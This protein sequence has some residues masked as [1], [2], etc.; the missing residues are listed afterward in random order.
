VLKN[1]KKIFFFLTINKTT[2]SSNIFDSFLTR[3][4]QAKMC[5][6]SA[7][8]VCAAAIIVGLK[9]LDMDLI[10]EH[11]HDAADGAKLSTNEKIA[12]GVVLA[13]GLIAAWCQ[14]LR[15]PL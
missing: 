4:E 8:I 3:S 2:M 1:I 7:M 9:A 15:A 5:Y 11:L 10:T 12:Y 14:Y 13:A 6:Y